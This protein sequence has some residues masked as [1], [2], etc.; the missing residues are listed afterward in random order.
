MGRTLSLGSDAEVVI[1]AQ[2]SDGFFRLFGVSPII[3]R[4]FTREETERA[5][6][7]SAAAHIGP[8]PVVILS[9]ET[10]QRLFGGDPG[11]LDRTIDLERRPFRVVG[12]MPAGFAMPDPGVRLWIPW[13]LDDEAPRDQHYLIAL[14]LM[15]PGT[16]VDEATDDL[17]R[18]AAELAGEYPESNRGWSVRLR[19]LGEDAIGQTGRVLWILLS[20]VGLV[21]V[22]VCANITLLSLTRGIERAHETALRLALGASSAR[23]LRQFVVESGLLAGAGGILGVTAAWAAIRVLP[24]VAPDLPRVDEVRF[25]GLTVLFVFIVTT[26]AALTAGLPSAWRRTRLRPAHTLS[27]TASRTLS[28]ASHS[29]RDAIVVAQ[30]ALAVVLLVGSSLLVRSFLVLRDTNPGFDPRGV[31]VLPIFLDIQGYNSGAKV[32]AYYATLFE[33]LAALPGVTAVGGAT[34]VPTNP[35][36]P[37]FERPVWPESR[38]ADPSARVPASVRLVTPGYFAAMGMA[39][40]QGRGFDSRDR[41]DAPAVVM[42]SET[43][44]ARLWPG[45]AATG[46]RLVVDYST[47][48]TYPYEVIGVVA[49]VR[50]R[51]PKSEPGA[52]I[53]L[54]HAQRSYL[55]LNVTVR[56]AGDPRTLVPEIREIMKRLDPQKPAHGMYVLEDLVD[57]TIASNR[58]V[59]LA[60]SAFAVAAVLL[61]VISVYGVLSH[62]VRERAREI[63]IRMAMGADSSRVV[64]WVARRGAALIAVGLGLGLGVATTLAGT[65]AGV[66]YGVQPIDPMS[67]AVAAVVLALVGLV[68][69]LVPALRAARIDPMATL[70]QS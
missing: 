52:E 55:I 62:R 8:D 7:N 59:M 36:G 48:G 69:T 39:V 58:H 24:T 68:A 46:Q 18:V 40:R 30:V 29:L 47:A 5:T 4:T 25:D 22:V 21:L 51:G 66:L 27:G 42:V 50:F 2:V 56:S 38:D 32:R 13:H 49:D 54:A 28:A 43:L 33:R 16:T 44:A 9:F 37:D 45:R 17:N 53:Y 10:W 63:G 41:V 12:V 64:A 70:R 19:P 1:G 35:L 26:I 31:L 65:L 57:D 15:K 20:A 67:G 3:G 6:F 61:S 11:I 60:L 14:G 23:L 34:T